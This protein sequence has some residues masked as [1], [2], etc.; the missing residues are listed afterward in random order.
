[1]L[2]EIMA[3]WLENVA[4]GQSLLTSFC[5]RSGARGRK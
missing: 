4:R 2:Q 5:R 3:K 1:M